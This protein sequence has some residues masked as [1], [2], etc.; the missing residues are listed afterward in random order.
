MKKRKSYEII[1]KAILIYILS[2]L[3]MCIAQIPTQE[4]NPIGAMFAM[5]WIASGL[6]A[7]VGA[8]FVY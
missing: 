1:S 5:I 8:L 3:G 4:L 7:A 2:L 6:F